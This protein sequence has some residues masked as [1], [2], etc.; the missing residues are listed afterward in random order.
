VQ[1]RLS[2][3]VLILGA[4][5]LGKRAGGI[6]V[7]LVRSRQAIRTVQIQVLPRYDTGATHGI[8][9]EFQEDQVRRV[10]T[11]LLTA[12]GRRAWAMSGRSTSQKGYTFS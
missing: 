2:Q 3:S 10:E 6:L 5:L 4:W 11:P 9:E 1:V 7:Q 12:P 8:T